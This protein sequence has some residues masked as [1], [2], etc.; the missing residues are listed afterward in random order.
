LTPRSGQTAA[1]A[2]APPEPAGE[3]PDPEAKKVAN[4]GRWALKNGDVSK[5]VARSRVPFKARGVIAA[6]TRDDLH[7]MLSNLVSEA[8]GTKTISVEVMTAA[9]VR[10]RFGSV[11]AGVQEG[12]G[13]LF[14]VAKVGG[15]TFVLVLE[16]TFGSWR[17]SGI[18]R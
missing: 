16:K 3:Q 6:R 8:S 4:A 10:R 5:M 11:P 17:V 7:A 9:G 14:G 13:R 18:S 12:S 15:D 2:P 1:P